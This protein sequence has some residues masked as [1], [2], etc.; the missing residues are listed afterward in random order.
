MAKKIGL[1]YSPSNSIYF[2]SGGLLSTTMYNFYVV[3]EYFL[4]DVI[5]PKILHKYVSLV[6]D[7]QL[8]FGVIYP[9]YIKSIMAYISV[10]ARYGG[11]SCKLS[12]LGVTSGQTGC[13]KSMLD[14]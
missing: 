9:Y 2:I 6:G 1:S 11:C 8:K 4:R 14:I 12:K 10:F 5:F 3:P 13:D 7:I